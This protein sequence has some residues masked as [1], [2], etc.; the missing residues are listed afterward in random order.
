MRNF[1]F[2]RKALYDKLKAAGYVV[3]NEIFVGTLVS[4]ESVANFDPDHDGHPGWR[5]DEIVAGRPGSSQGK[6]AEWLTTEKPNI[7][8]LHIGTNDVSFSNEGWNEVEDVLVVIDDYEATSGKAVWVI[9]S[10]II[11]RSCDPLSS[12]LSQIIGDEHF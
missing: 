10:L 6:L 12:T 8:L 7:V 11:D 2:R 4:G 3:N 5:T 9:L 1:R